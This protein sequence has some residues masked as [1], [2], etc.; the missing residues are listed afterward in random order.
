MD[1]LFRSVRARLALAGLLFSGV[2]CVYWPGLAGGFLFDDYPVVFKN[3]HV[4][5]TALDWSSIKQALGGF[6]HGEYGRPLATLSFALNYLA[7]GDN[8]WGYKLVGLLIHAFNAVLVWQLVFR[9][10]RSPISGVDKK[11][12]QWLAFLTASI[13]AVH[14]LQVSSVLYIVQR[15]EVLATT[16]VFISLLFYL[17]GRERQ[18]EGRPRGWLWIGGAVIV[19]IVGMLSKETAALVGL[20]ALCIELTLLRFDARS[21]GSSRWLKRGYALMVVGGAVFALYLCLKY[22][23][24][25]TYSGRWFTVGERILTQFRA[26]PTYLG[27]ILLPTPGS[28][29]FYYDDIVASH[30]L[31]DPITTLAGA[32]LLGALL[33]FGVVI[34]RRSPLTAL[35]IFWFFAAH[36]LSSSPINLELVFEHRNYFALLGVVLAFLCGSHALW[37]AM[38]FRMLTFASIAMVMGLSC[39]TWIRSATWGDPLLLAMELAQENPKSPRAAT[40]LAEQYMLLSGM[41]SDS[42][43]YNMARDE[44]LRAAALPQASPLPETGLMLMIGTSGKQ[45]TSDIWSSLQGKIREN[46]LGAQEKLAVES[47]LMQYYDGLPIEAGNLDDTIALMLERFQPDSAAYSKYADFLLRSGRSKAR[48]VDLYA[49]AYQVS[50]RDPNYLKRLEADLIAAGH[51]DIAIRL[52]TRVRPSPQVIDSSKE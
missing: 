47:L 33:T 48:A 9:L 1:G 12:A 4:H 16:F 3:A 51:A 17:T 14:P 44:Y 52:A 20:Y 37:R 11:G 40:D 7:G 21:P 27:Q 26:L 25:E 5:I 31:T 15:M 45:I 41:R 10:V 43:F 22:A 28:M 32:L 49:K 38:D 24:A 2:V 19:A 39:L 50:N 30:S 35:G 42:P 18:L 6:S 8:P 34:R 23:N 46:P 29:Y 36:V 13:W